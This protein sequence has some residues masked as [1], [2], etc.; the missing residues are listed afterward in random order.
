M[1]TMADKR[2]KCC[3]ND[4]FDIFGPLSD[5]QKIGRD[6]FSQEEIARHVD[7]ID[8]ADGAPIPKGPYPFCHMGTWCKLWFQDDDVLTI[9]KKKR[10]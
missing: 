3:L 5:S 8:D 4:Y 6:E 7:T 2:R 10:D 1:P 9:Y